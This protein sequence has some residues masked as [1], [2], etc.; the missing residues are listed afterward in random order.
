MIRFVLVRDCHKTETDPYDEPLVQY[1]PL[2]S[3]PED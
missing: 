1:V 2:T 3:S